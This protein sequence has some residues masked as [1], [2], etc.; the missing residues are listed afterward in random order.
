AAP[1][2][3]QPG[4]REPAG[5]GT[6]ALDYTDAMLASRRVVIT[7]IGGVSPF[8]VGRERFW[9]HL[10]HG[11][12]ATRAITH[13]DVSS[14]P[15][16]VAAWVPAVSIDDAPAIEGDDENDGRTDAKRSSRAAIFGVIAAREAWVDAGLRAGEP[17]A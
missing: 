1:D 8:G 13:F 4:P 9:Q 14:Y 15:C 7:R 12:S 17:H 11:C 16:Q 2:K 6:H 5:G 3:R 10:S